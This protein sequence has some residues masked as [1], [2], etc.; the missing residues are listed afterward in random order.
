M[1][2]QYQR[3]CLDFA[4]GQDVEGNLV[5][6]SIYRATLPEWVWRISTVSGSAKW[7]ADPS[8]GGNPT[9]LDPKTFARFLML[10]SIA[11]C[12]LFTHGAA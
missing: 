3:R 6:R 5:R 7:A 11:G 2:E 9:P 4:C 10:Q 12:E 8:A 1:A